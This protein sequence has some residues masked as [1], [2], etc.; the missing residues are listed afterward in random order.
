MKKIIVLL[1]LLAVCSYLFADIVVIPE[2]ITP[3][4][5]S[6]LGGRHS[7]PVQITADANYRGIVQPGR[8]V[9]V[10]GD[11][12]CV[13]YSNTTSDPNNFQRF[14]QAYSVDGGATWTPAT[15]GTADVMRT[16][17]HHDVLYDVTTD[18]DPI[19]ANP[20]IFWLERLYPT[21]ASAV[22]F[23]K[24]DLVPYSIF[25]PIPVDSVI[26]YFPT[27][28]AWGLG[29]T[30]FGTSTDVNT[31]D[32]FAYR[33]NDNG[34]TWVKDANLSSIG[35]NEGQVAAMVDNGKDGF[36]V[37]MFSIQ[38]TANDFIQSYVVQTTDYGQTWTSPVELFTP[39]GSGS[40]TLS[41][42]WMGYSCVVDPADDMPYFFVKLDTHKVSNYSFNNGELYF[43]K[44]NGGTPGS[45]TFDNNNP[46]GVV[47]GDPGIFNHIAGFPT[48]GFYRSAVDSST[49]LYGF[50]NALAAGAT[51]TTS[52]IFASTSTD[53]GVTWNEVQVT[54][55]Y[56]TAFAK[57]YTS[58]SYYVNVATGE[59]S[60]VFA[61][62]TPGVG[63]DTDHLPMHHFKVDVV[64]DLGLPAAGSYVGVEE[65]IGVTLPNL[66]NITAI[67]TGGV[68]NFNVSLPEGGN[69]SLQIFD[70]TG[71][72]VA[73]IVNTYLSAG[74]HNFNWNSENSSAGSYIYRMT[75]GG[76]ITSGKVLIA[77]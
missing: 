69:T 60:V 63:V 48:I 32:I 57:D 46:V 65:G 73:Q 18:G 71:R 74:V 40:S 49:I 8:N 42:T 72:E 66:Y 68:C 9:S 15:V 13:I 6:V 70:A 38:A 33:S 17:P 61:K 39:S 51:D 10:H 5:K 55:D 20:Y 7:T 36:G 16:Y 62:W 28:M 34:V 35:S 21:D 45:Y 27:V 23:T 67:N 30:L 29:D 53:L 54:D 76:Y 3:M 14:T 52:E 26:G 2:N 19:S 31:D 12:I 22:N 24:D 25:S 37:A 56:D 75:S 50:Y 44:P 11:T 43:I 1:S 64:T 77:E 47:T 59:V 41:M 58:S 4:S